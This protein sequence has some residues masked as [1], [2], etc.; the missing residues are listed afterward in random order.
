MKKMFLNTRR[1]PS[2]NAAR[3][4]YLAPTAQPSGVTCSVLIIDLLVEDG[5]ELEN[6]VPSTTILPSNKAQDAL[7]IH[8]SQS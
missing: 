8:L 4:L 7:P 5:S 1:M 2:G 3:S 6:T